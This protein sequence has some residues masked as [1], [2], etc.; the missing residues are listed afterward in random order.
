MTEQSPWRPTRRRLTDGLL[1]ALTPVT[2]CSLALG[3]LTTWVGAG[4][5]GSPARV[6]VS[7]A[8]V[9]LPY[10]DTKETA[11]FFDLANAGGADDRLVKVTSS[12]THGG[13]TLSRHRSAGSGAAAKTDA[14]SAVVPAGR[15]LSMSPHGLDVNLR[16]GAG[17]RT[18]DLVP[19]TLHFERSGAIEALAVVVRPG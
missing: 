12:R 10:G 7:K 5:A 18:G 14:D 19:F 2:A 9:L 16:A 13:I 3:G 17:W 4:K 6:T 15:T 11:A 1:A 8:R